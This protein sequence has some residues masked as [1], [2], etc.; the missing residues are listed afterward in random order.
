MEKRYIQFSYENKP[1]VVEENG[2][3][4]RKLSMFLITIILVIIASKNNVDKDII[5]A[6]ILSLLK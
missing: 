4:I 2:I 5:I 1:L 6:L 3:S